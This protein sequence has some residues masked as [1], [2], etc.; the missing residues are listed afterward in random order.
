MSTMSI[1]RIV[2]PGVV[3]VEAPGDLPDAVLLPEEAPIVDRAVEARRRE[4]ATARCLARRGLEA[5]GVD[6]LPILPGPYREPRWPAGIVGSITHCT[7]Y[8]AAA[9]ARASVLTSIGIDAEPNADLPDGVLS[10]VSRAEERERLAA[11]PSDGTCWGRLLFSAKESVFKTWFPVARRWLDFES[12]S[13][14]FR[15]SDQSFRAD[16]IG[17]ELPL[18]SGGAHG[19]DGRYVIRDAHVLTAVTIAERGC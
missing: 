3:V 1:A 16:F 10:L 5:L 14:R 15:P 7:G 6:P 9:V 18:R 19:L 8:R 17:T 4:F 2:P 13:I 12:V 11:L